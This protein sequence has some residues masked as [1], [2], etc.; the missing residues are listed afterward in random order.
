MRSQSRA[1]HVSVNHGTIKGII[2]VLAQALPIMAVVSLFPVIPKLMQQFGGVPHGAF[3]VPMIITLPSLGIALLSPAAGWLADRFGRRP[4]IVGSLAIYAV[5]GLAPLVLN[6]LTAVVLSRALLGV[7]EAGIVTVASTL[8]ADY[9]GENRYR[10][11]AI[12]SGLGSALGTLLIA[13]GG[14]LAEDSWRGPF[15]VYAAA[16][17]LLVLAFLFI[18]E[19]VAQ[20]PATTTT[21][22]S[23]FPW[24]IALI[25]GVVSLI[26][27]VLYYVEPTN[28]ATLFLERGATSS[29]QIGLIQA[30]TSMAYIVGAFVYRRLSGTGAGLLLAISGILIGAGMIGIGL[31]HSLLAAALWALPQQ[32][33]GG[34]V[35]PALTGWAQGV[36][37]FD[38]RGRAMGIWATFFFGGL[39]LCPTLV[40]LTT[41]SVGTLSTA[42]WALGL[43]ACAAAALSLVCARR[44][45]LD[46]AKP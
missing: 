6:D 17:P 43:V 36:M 16:V 46:A 1:G 33:G 10:W 39:F 38:Q 27:S 37:P 25:V 32:L 29:S 9:F 28:V 41:G 42:F 35:I 12:Q 13:L 21:Q 22:A 4:V 45:R 2:L 20:R 5:T 11:L 19:P 7:A 3:L 34:M 8:I 30:A 31:S 24:G 15:A 26:A 44:P 18:D 23:R 14:L 40:T